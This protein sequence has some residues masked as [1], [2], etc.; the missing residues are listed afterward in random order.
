[1]TQRG[2]ETRADG[3]AGPGPSGCGG[4][5]LIEIVAVLVVLGIL[6]AL[7]VSRTG[8]EDKGALAARL[9]EL[10]SQIRYVQ[11]AA[12]K[13]G[14]TYLAMVCDGTRYWA[15]Y[16]NGTLLLLPA[17]NATRVTLSDKSL[18]VSAFNL[19]FDALGIPLDGASGAKLTA[20][21]TIQVTRAGASGSIG[22]S[23]E[24]GFTQ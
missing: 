1:M 7:L 3:R 8:N 6:S 20:P 15:Q 17:E 12:M 10:R 16:D 19:R 5:T 14:A 11:L 4:F 13:S 18:T 9:S 23:P 2:A 21:L 22:V 24:T